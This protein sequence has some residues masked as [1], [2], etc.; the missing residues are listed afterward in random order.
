V[1]YP[2]LFDLLFL[3][4]ASGISPKV[5]LEPVY[6]LF[7]ELV[8]GEFY[9]CI[10]EKLIKK[11]SARETQRGIKLALHG[12]LLFYMNRRHAMEY[13]ELIKEIDS[14]IDLWIKK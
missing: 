11:H 3:E 4:K 9:V 12:L 8:S 5:S 10:S 14:I 2:G 7:D 6:T 1:Q 13:P